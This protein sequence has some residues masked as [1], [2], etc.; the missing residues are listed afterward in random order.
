MARSPAV[1]QD[2]IPEAHAL[3]ELQGSAGRQIRAMHFFLV[4][5]IVLFVIHTL[6]KIGKGQM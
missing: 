1:G 4:I 2:D 5:L 3:G 6:N